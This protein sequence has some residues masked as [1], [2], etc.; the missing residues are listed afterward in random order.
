M[1]SE[2]VLGRTSQ[3]NTKKLFKVWQKTKIFQ[4]LHFLGGGYWNSSIGAKN[5]I[6][7]FRFC[8]TF[9]RVVVKAVVQPTDCYDFNACD[10]LFHSCA[11]RRPD[12]FLPPFVRLTSSG[13]GLELCLRLALMAVLGMR[14]QTP[15]RT[16]NFVRKYISTFPIGIGRLLKIQPL[17]SGAFG[18]CSEGMQMVILMNHSFPLLFLLGTRGMMTK[19]KMPAKLTVMLKFCSFFK[20]FS[21]DFQFKIK[22]YHKRYVLLGK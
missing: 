11:K 8:I 17:F 20:L 9:N 19:K 3:E 14:L 5:K 6:F 13:I 12:S 1:T 15:F 22:E 16:W 10:A 4:T 18:G 7:Q 2:Q 21:V